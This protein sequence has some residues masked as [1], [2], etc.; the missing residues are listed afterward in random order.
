MFARTFALVFTLLVAGTMA[1]RAD[2]QYAV[3]GHDSFRIT[4]SAVVRTRLSRDPMNR[5]T[6][7]MTNVQT[8]FDLALT[9]ILLFCD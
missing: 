1:A 5:A 3:D 2:Q 7:V 6:D 9:C 8:V 4:G